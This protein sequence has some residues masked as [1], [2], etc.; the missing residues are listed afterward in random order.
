VS[1]VL[2]GRGILVTGGNSGIGKV[3]ARACVAAGADV[4]ICGRSMASLETAK[5]ELQAIAWD[6]QRV[7]AIAADVSDPKAVR[8][9]VSTVTTQITSLSGLVNAAGILGPKGDLDEVD[10]DEWIATIQV[11]LIGT[12]LL[13][14]AVLPH[15]RTHGYGRIVNFSG[16]GATS[17]RPRFSAYAASKAAV[18]RLTENLAQELEGTGIFVNAMAPGAVNTRMLEEVLEAGPEKVGE[19]AY[20]D[21][22]KQKASGGISAEKAAALCVMLL[23]DDS[24]GVNGRLISAVWDPWASLAERKEERARSDI[25]TLRRIVPADRG[26]NWD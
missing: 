15:F 7:S 25:Y 10:L 8:Q 9:L 17:P 26:L 24:H 16:G 12:M 23:A 3:V 5:T 1:R 21:A 18:V 14:R 2:A 11:N 20:K 22:L 19:S 4:A 6:G 13:C